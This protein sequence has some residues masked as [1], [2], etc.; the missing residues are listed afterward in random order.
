MIA[1]V[2]LRKPSWKENN[3]QVAIAMVNVF[4]HLAKAPGFNKG[5]ASLLLPGLVD[6]L[7]DMKLKKLA[8]DCMTAI[9]EGTSL[10]FVLSQSE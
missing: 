2:L 6:K 3:F 8:S 10:Q 4:T 7:A 1:R 9:A 5:T